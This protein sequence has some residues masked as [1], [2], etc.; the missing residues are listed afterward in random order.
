MVTAKGRIWTAVEAWGGAWP[1]SFRSA[2]LSAPEDADLLD[3]RSWQFS[4]LVS[5]PR[6][7][8]DI[9]PWRGFLEG[10]FVV[11]PDGRFLVVLREQKYDG[12]RVHLVELSDNGLTGIPKGPMPFPGG[13]KK[14]SIK[15]DQVSGRYWTLTSYLQT[16]PHVPRGRLHLPY[17]SWFYQ[18]MNVR[19]YQLLMSS[20]DLYSWQPHQVVVETTSVESA[21]YSDFIFSGD[22]LLVVLRCALVDE[23]GQHANNPNYGNAIGFKRLRNFRQLENVSDVEILDHNSLPSLF[24]RRM[25]RIKQW[26]IPGGPPPET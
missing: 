21:S 9:W 3:A 18:A 7:W 2:V 22:D 5:Y 13:A 15:Y 4:S 11:A 14:F 17:A 25:R 24:Q 20:K 12:G 1:Q 23:H 6:S 19:Q 10:N 26:M 16:E 8:Q